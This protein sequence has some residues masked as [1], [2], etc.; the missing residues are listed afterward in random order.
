MYQFR[1]IRFNKIKFMIMLKSIKIALSLSLLLFSSML[2]NPA[3]AQDKTDMMKNST[4]EQRAKMLTSMMKT[5]LQL[6]TVQVVKVLA[7]NLAAA[8]KMEPVIK[9]DGGRFA[10]FRQ[11]KEIESTKD[12][13]LKKVL[14]DAQYKQYEAGKDEMKE[15]MKERLQEKKAGKS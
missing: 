15:K 6:D 7:I 5:K 12:K 2:I 9:G 3:F 4:P 14:T 13:E 10:K 8:Q 1:Y 11:A